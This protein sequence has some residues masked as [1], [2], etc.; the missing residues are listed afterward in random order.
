ME[1]SEVG[2]DNRFE[3]ARSKN[4]HHVFDGRYYDGIRL[5]RVLEALFPGQKGKFGL[6][7]GMPPLLAVLSLAD[8]NGR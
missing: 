7:V 2:I 6:R 5:Q 4:V 8:L 1:Q 3:M